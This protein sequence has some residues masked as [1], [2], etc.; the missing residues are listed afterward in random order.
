M[1]EDIRSS[2]Q[3]LC[4]GDFPFESYGIEDPMDLGRI[5]MLKKKKG[6]DGSKLVGVL[7]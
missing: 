3:D 1:N 7:A 5:D 4:G 6:D 2:L